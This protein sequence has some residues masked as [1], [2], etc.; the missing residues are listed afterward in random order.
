MRSSNSFLISAVMLMA[1]C[2]SG[3]EKA[4]TTTTPTPTAA[5]A[6]AATAKV[7]VIDPVG[8]YEFSTVVDGQS[9]TGTLTIAGAPGSYTGKIVTNMFPEIPVIGARVEEK[10]VIATATMPDGELTIRMLMD[11]NQFTGRWELGGE[12]GE[13]NGKKLPK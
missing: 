11:G 3:Q 6:V 7:V 4:A 12:T 8:A 5:A 9:V 13:F 2:A 1:A 10:T